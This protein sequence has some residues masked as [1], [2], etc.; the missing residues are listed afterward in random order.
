MPWSLN[1]WTRS[2]FSLERCLYLQ[3]AK[4][5]AYCLGAVGVVT[6]KNSATGSTMTGELVFE[7]LGIVAFLTRGVACTEVSGAGGYGN[8]LWYI[9]E[10]G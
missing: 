10:S 4:R 1:S 3:S 7:L 6:C 8:G 2:L 9:G 5:Q